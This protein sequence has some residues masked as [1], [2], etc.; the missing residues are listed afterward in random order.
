MKYLALIFLLGC[1]CMLE[2]Q[3]KE[4]RKDQI[5][6]CTDTRDGEKFSFNTNDV[7]QIGIGV[8]VGT[9]RFRVVDENGKVWEIHD[10]DSVWLKCHPR[11]EESER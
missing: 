5:Y 2:G 4:D 6:D 3:V 8:L 1:G 7:D 11:K 10:R 9:Y